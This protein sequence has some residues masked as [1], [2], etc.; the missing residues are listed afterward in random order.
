M[1]IIRWCI[2]FQI[3]YVDVLDQEVFRNKITGIYEKVELFF[4]LLLLERDYVLERLQ[5]EVR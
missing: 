2:H 1:N 5:E 4:F 3:N